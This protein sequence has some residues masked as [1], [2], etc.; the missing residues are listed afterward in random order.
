MPRITFID[1]A[2][3]ARCVEAVAGETLMEAGVKSGVP[4]LEAECGG[5]CAC[6]TCHVY[7]DPAFLAKLSAPSDVEQGMLDY[8]EAPVRENSRLSC[9]IIVSDELDGMTVHTPPQQ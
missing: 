4:E 7:V 5:A 1:H 3:G 2:G 9:Q 6:A 8:A